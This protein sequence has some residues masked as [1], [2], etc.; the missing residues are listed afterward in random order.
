MERK[1]IKGRIPRIAS[2][3]SKL[4]PGALSALRRGPMEGAGVAAYW[5][6][7]VQHEIGPQETAWSQLVQAIAILTPRG[8]QENKQS[9]HLTGVSMGKALYSA[10]VSEGRL[11]TL[12]GAPQALRPDLAVRLCRR[13]ARSENA[14]FNL[15]TL[16]H[17]VLGGGVVT[18][19]IIAKEYYRAEYKKK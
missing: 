2:Q 12:L 11:A 7:A 5:R 16:G 6:L 9:A 10:G 15:V 14:R 1:S 17:Y 13:L 18:D 3:I 19:R 4:G 8:G